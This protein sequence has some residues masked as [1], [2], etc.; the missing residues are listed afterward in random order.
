MRPR[1]PAALLALWPGHLR[2][3]LLWV[4]SLSLLGALGLLGGYT[5]S[6]QA[7]IALRAYENQAAA[8]ARN[9]ATSG[10]NLILT[11][12]LDQLEALVLRSADFDEVISVRVIEVGGRALSQVVRPSGQPPRLVFAS[13]REKQAV[14]SGRQP[15]V[16]TDLAHDRIT[17]WQPVLA[18]EP[19]AWVRVE[20]NAHALRQ[21]QHLIWR[22]TL[23]VA[24]LA[25]SLCAGALVIFLRRPMKQ[26]DRARRFANILPNAEG[27]QL[28]YLPGPVEFVELDAALN[29]ASMLLRQQMLVI[30]QGMHK[31]QAQQARMGE[32][33]DQLGAIFAMSPDGLMTFNRDD[34]VQF[35][36][37]AFLS[38]TGLEPGQVQGQSAMAVDTLLRSLV[39]EGGE[40]KGLDHC[41]DEGGQVMVRAGTPPRVLTLHGQCSESGSVSRVLYVCDVTRQHQLDQMKSEFLSM[42]AHELRTPMVSIFGFTELMMKREMAPEMRQDLLGRIYRHSQSMVAILNELLDL[43][44]IESRRGQDFKMVPADLAEVVAEVVGDF[45]PPEG[46]EPPVCAPVPGPMPVQVDRHKMQQAVLNILSNAYK[47]SP[48]G[49][50]VELRYLVGDSQL[51]GKRFAVQ[52]QDHG[53]GLSPENLARMGERFFRADKSG[54]IPGTGLGVSIVK[55]LMGLMGGRMVVESAP[56]EGT[57]VTLWL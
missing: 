16:D 31:L 42:A 15:R 25:V 55:E 40:F 20:Y 2:Q 52:I 24:V 17:A 9:V 23:V 14:P 21:L 53:M 36:N 7:S 27:G 18:G 13:I 46:R 39:A 48:D 4:V 26:L 37:Q 10:T 11:D 29:E 22:N 35:V 47:Y 34:H 44:R 5:A 41:F 32:Q 43:A 33:N 8:L 45:K 1:L 49:G 12:S 56:G 28:P 54:N 51:P 3:Q 38:L 50:P 30:D 19:I 57:T 6:E